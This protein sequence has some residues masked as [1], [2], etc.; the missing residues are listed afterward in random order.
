MGSRAISLEDEMT[1]L[2]A[3]YRL[4][5]AE[6]SS[7]PSVTS[8]RMRARTANSRVE[9]PVWREKCDEK[10]TENQQGHP[11]LLAHPAD[12]A[13]NTIVAVEGVALGLRAARS[14]S[15]SRVVH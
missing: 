6:V 2:G 8:L 11:Y 7:E 10:I 9:S 14:S 12:G 1:V 5:A 13:V 4:R 15:S 3:W